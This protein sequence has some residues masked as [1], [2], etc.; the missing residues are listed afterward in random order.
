MVAD[1]WIIELE[2][3]F[4]VMGCNDEQKIQLASFLLSEDAGAWWRS[5]EQSY[6]G[7]GQGTWAQFKSRFNN[8]YFLSHVKDALAEEFASLRQG[9]L[10]VAQYGS[11]FRTLSRYAPGY[12]STE[13]DKVRKFIGRLRPSIMTSIILLDP[14]TLT[15]ACKK[16]EVAERSEKIIQSSRMASFGSKI[17]APPQKKQKVEGNNSV[18][19]CSTCGKRHAGQCWRTLEVCYTCGDPG[20]RQFNCPRLGRQPV[21][22]PVRP[23]QQTQPSR[24]AAPAQN[25]WKGNQNR[26]QNAGRDAQ[27]SRIFTLTRGDAEAPNY[28]GGG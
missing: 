21:G 12:A 7:V 23:P 22:A 1:S 3:I 9:N 28:S 19:L 5:V 8:Q 20:H 26:P 13:A 17:S 14:E 11:K 2:R 15:E 16:A 6:P 18:A 4:A 25:Q 24:Q 10:T 27:S